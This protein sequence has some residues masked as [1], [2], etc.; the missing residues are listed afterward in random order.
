MLRLLHQVRR[1]PGRFVEGESLASRV[2]CVHVNVNDIAC[3]LVL[4]LVGSLCDL[5][6]KDRSLY[7]T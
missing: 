7:V 3:L 2:C 5:T 1:G 4:V 6:V